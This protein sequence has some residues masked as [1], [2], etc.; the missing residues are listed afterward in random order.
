MSYD[1]VVWL[2]VGTGLGVAGCLLLLMLFSTLEWVRLG[3]R[4]KQARLLRATPTP[5]VA[6]NRVM[7]EQA[8]PAPVEM[9]TLVP[10]PAA[11]VVVAVAEADEKRPK[12][13]DARSLIVPPPKPRPFAPGTARARPAAASKPVDKSAAPPPKP[14]LKP[15]AA[16]PKAPAKLEVVAKEES[17]P[18]DVAAKPLPEGVAPAVAKQDVPAVPAVKKPAE[19]STAPKPRITQTPVAPPPTIVAANDVGP[20]LR[21][22]V[23]ANDKPAA[24]RPPIKQA[25]SFIA[26]ADKKP[27]AP[28]S[29]AVAPDPVGTKPP[30]AVTEETPAAAPVRN[31]KALFGDTFKIEK[32]T[33][34]GALPL[35]DK[36]EPERK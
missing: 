27:T 36:S 6:A 14:V 10:E 29:A 11:V 13:V 33:V 34:P 25:R 18:A 8:K 23:V 28:E 4:L 20:K 19:V 7:P 24:P 30:Q 26:V 31:V 32:L 9:N 35:P 15:V 3:R 21:L 2:L 16:V 17:K 1:A 12:P 22:T 5:R